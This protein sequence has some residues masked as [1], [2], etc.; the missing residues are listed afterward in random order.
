[1][2][3]SRAGLAGM[4]SRAS[5]SRVVSLRSALADERSGQVVF[6]AHCLLDQNTRYLG[7]AFRPGAVGE[8]VDA[9]LRNGAGICQLPCPERVAWGGVLKP[10]LLAL[11]GRPSLRPAIHAILPLLLLYTRLRYR[12]FARRVAAEVE[13]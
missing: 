6:L 13:D 8:V 9:Y 11:Y 10:R 7:G 4:T 12:L 3:R 2:I 1:M 5:H